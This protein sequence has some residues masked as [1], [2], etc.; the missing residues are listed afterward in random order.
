MELGLVMNCPHCGMGHSGTCPRIRAI[1]YHPNGT[2]KR[3]EFHSPQP[4]FG[5]TQTDGAD[6]PKRFT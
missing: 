4:P 2:V 5:Q 6:D 3:I 1:E